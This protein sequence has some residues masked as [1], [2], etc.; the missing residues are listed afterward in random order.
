MTKKTWPPA[1]CSP[2]KKTAFQKIQCLCR[3]LR[4]LSK[5]NR[6]KNT[7]R[8]SPPGVLPYFLGWGQAYN[9]EYWKIPLVYGVL[10]IPTALFFYN[11]SYYKKTKFAYEA[12]YAERVDHDTT[13]LPLIDP[14]LKNL[15]LENLQN[16]RNA[17][18][19]D[20]DYSILWFLAAWGLQVADATVFAH[21]KE[22]NVN[23]D[24]SMQVKP[25]FNPQTRGPG[26]SLTF[27]L[28]NTKHSPVSR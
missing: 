6:S 11:N 19:R 26:L 14:E 27:N 21:L 28:R 16:Y 24:L 17:F 9:K 5:K 23:D 2:L 12:R 18:R 10:A 20:R 15:S 3:R 7:S 8:A 13:L 25:L 22:F 4:L 1:A